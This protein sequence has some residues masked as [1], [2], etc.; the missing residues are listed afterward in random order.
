M[1]FFTIFTI[2]H[3]LL[4][5]SPPL[6]KLV[7]ADDQLIQMECHNAEVPTTCMLCL[8]S[9]RGA[10]AADKVGIATILVNCL[11]NH[12]NTLAANM[13]DLVSGTKDQVVKIV[14]HECGQGYSS[15]KKKLSSATSSLKSGKYDDAERF[16]N[17]A[18]KYELTCHSKIGSY[19]ERI[20][21]D[22]VH[23]MK[24]YEELSE[25]AKRIVERL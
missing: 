13:S 3:L 17:E 16:V 4:T 19:K 14:L 25:A 11:K 1:T 18:L 12:A 24:I 15:A 22:I 23:E 10:A 21:E 2:L 20:P 5:P 8:K 6:L 9:D 7:R